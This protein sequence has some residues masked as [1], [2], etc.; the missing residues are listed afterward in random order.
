MRLV[1]GPG[2]QEAPPPQNTDNRLAEM[3][4]IQR[5]EDVTNE[6][7][8]ETALAGTPSAGQAQGHP[9]AGLA[10]RA[11]LSGCVRAA[12]LPHALRRGA[13]FFEPGIDRLGQV[14]VDRVRQLRQAAHARQRLPD[15]SWRHPAL[16]ADRRRGRVRHRAGAG[17]AAQSR[18]LWAQPVPRAHPDPLDG[19]A[20]GR[21]PD[22]ALHVRPEPGGL[23]LLYPRPGRQPAGFP[24]RSEDCP[25]RTGR[26][27]G[28]AL[29]PLHGAGAPGRAAVDPQGTARGGPGRRGERHSE[30]L[31]YHVA[32]HQ[33]RDRSG[34]A[35]PHGRC[36]AHL[37]P[38]LPDDRRWPR[39]RHGG[40]QHVH[41]PLGLPQF[42][43]RLHFGLVDDLAHRHAG[44][45]RHLPTHA[46]APPGIHAR[47]LRR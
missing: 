18:V 2:R 28:V 14:Q 35:L 37:R 9:P 29:Q 34:A 8:Q 20:A 19:A 47:R 6:A 27:R 22:V 16:C 46:G 32:V 41:L 25:V 44:D 36:P 24:G 5:T 4:A 39:H 45:L 30:L 3:D 17:A 26:H 15:R 42:P 13:R 31:V 1:R 33:P 38:G 21:R 23:L 43:A 12:R 11:D 7:C 40:R 10:D